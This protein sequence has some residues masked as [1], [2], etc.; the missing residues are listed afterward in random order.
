M[1]PHPLLSGLGFQSLYSSSEVR[2]RLLNLSTD[3][4]QI[5][6]IDL[7]LIFPSI[8]RITLQPSNIQVHFPQ[9]LI[10]CLFD[11]TLPIPT[12]EY[13]EVENQIEIKSKT[14]RILQGQKLG[15]VDL[16]LCIC[17]LR[18]IS[19][20]LAETL[21]QRNVQLVCLW[22]KFARATIPTLFKYHLRDVLLWL[23]SRRH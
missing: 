11:N 1:L 10:V 17:N 12:L 15:V 20:L 8:S 7:L 21:E 22:G 23:T 18:R 13:K 16:Q 3:F 2:Y 19:E 4:V 6:T 5:F 14:S 9:G